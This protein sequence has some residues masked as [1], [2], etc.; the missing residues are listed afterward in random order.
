MSTALAQQH[1]GNVL[2]AVTLSP[3]SAAHADPDA[4]VVHPLVARLGQVG[5]LQDVQLLAV[6]RESW[7][8]VQGA[9]VDAL[10]AL[11]G[12]LRVDV[13]DPPRLRAKRGADEL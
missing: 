10:H 8:T 2:L 7:P 11:P 4:L 5:A 9:V 1:A 3:T 6:P 13:Q 12:V